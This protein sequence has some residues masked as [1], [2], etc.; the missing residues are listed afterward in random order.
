LL[1]W[2]APCTFIALA[3]NLSRFTSHVGVERIGVVFG[4][5]RFHYRRFYD[6]NA[7][8]VSILLVPDLILNLLPALLPFRDLEGFNNGFA[9][10]EAYDEVG[11]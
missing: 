9:A 2:G 8:S 4:L 10:C 6:S 1:S 3:P 11:C 7:K 5:L